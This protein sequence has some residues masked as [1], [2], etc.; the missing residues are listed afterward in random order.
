MRG[1][2]TSWFSVGS[3]LL[4]ALVAAVSSPQQ[5]HAQ[6]LITNGSFEVDDCGTSG[7]G[8]RLG[9]SGNDMTG[10]FIPAGDGTYPWCLQ[11]SNP[12]GAGPAAQGNQWLALGEVTSGVHYTIQQTLTGLSS[13]SVYALTF[14][15][16]SELGCCSLAQVS[17]L[18]GSSTPNQTFTAPASGAYWLQ[19]GQQTMS[20]TASA[21]SVTIQFRDMSAGTN[22][23]DLG[24]DNVI[25]TSTT[26]E[27]ASMAL[28]A[29]GLVG[30]A[31]M[32]FKRRRNG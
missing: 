13:G 7:N 24:L 2:I 20:F 21:S 16:A 28:L 14:S 30:I 18:S 11:N 32:G 17:F 6:N 3:P 22:S 4:L 10:W 9:L 29:T 25:V 12:Y 5:A 8:Q 23:Y 26:P 27:P 15:I 1:R 19:W 31:G